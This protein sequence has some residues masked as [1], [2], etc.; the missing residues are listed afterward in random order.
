M[1]PLITITIIAEY[2]RRGAS[3]VTIVARNKSKLDTAVQD[4]H[5]FVE[6]S[7]KYGSQQVFGVSVDVGSSEAE[8]EK[9]LSAHLKNIGDVDVLVNCAGN[10]TPFHALTKLESPLVLLTF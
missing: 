4:L 10:S 8:V 5:G 6:K 9:A 2:L 3:V 7:C 1:E